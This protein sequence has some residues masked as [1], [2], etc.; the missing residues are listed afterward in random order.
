MENVQIEVK[1]REVIGKKLSGLRKA[2]LIPAVV[3]GKKIKPMSVVV[4]LKSFTKL[5]M[6]S[7]AGRN[8]IIS[9]AIDEKTSIPVLTHAIQRNATTDQILHIDFLNIVMDEVLRTKVPVELVGI[10]IGVKED[11][12]ILIH[13]I[14]EL[15]VECLPSDIPEKYE[16]DV[17]ALKV[18]D[19]LHVS[20]LVK[21]EK[22][23]V[24]TSQSEMIANCA[25]PAKEEVV[26]APIPTPG[27]VPVTAQGEAPA[28]GA[29]AADAAAPAAKPA[30]AGKPEKAAK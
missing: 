21:I 23:K 13:G 16:I 11:G 27:E 5:V 25:P 4:D 17:S 18:N 15:E 20:D 12:G 8:S 14:R 22:V 2:G 9:L 28:E 24:L 6:Q 30:P 26:A 3:Y 1:K 7:D 10:P 19:L 29:K